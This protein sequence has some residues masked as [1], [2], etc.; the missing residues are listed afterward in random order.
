MRM[1]ICNQKI[2]EIRK[3]RNRTIKERCVKIEMMNMQ[4]DMYTNRII[5]NKGVS[6]RKTAKPE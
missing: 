1:T 2:K 5:P 3:T 4:K 6:T